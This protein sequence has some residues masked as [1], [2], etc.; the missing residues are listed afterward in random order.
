MKKTS[1]WLIYAFL[2][3][4][5]LITLFTVLHLGKSLDTPSLAQAAETT[6]KSPLAFFAHHLLNPLSL[7]L[8]QI[9]V[10]FPIAQIMG[11]FFNKMGQPRVVGEIVAGIMLGPSILGALSQDIYTFVFP[12]HSLGTLRLMSHI[13]ILIFMFV[14]GMDVNIKAFRKQAHQTLL[15]SHTGIILP[16]I[17]GCLLAGFLFESYKGPNVTFHSF[18]LFMGVAMSITAFPVL[19]RILQEKNLSSSAIGVTALASAAIDDVTAWTLLAL[20]VAWVES[21]SGV[22]VFY[23][24]GFFVLFLM[25]LLLIVRPFLKNHFNNE[26]SVRS[27]KIAF[28]LWLVFVC[29]LVTESIGIHAIFG[30]FIAGVIMPDSQKFKIFISEKLEYFSA[31]FLLPLFFAVVG[32]R[33]RIDLLNDFH[34][35]MVCLVI[36][37]TATF[38]KF[39][40]TS[41]AA[42]FTGMS[43]RDSCSIG[44]LMNARGLM[45]LI[46]L[47]LG[48]EMG[49][50]SEKIFA[51]MIIMALVTTFMTGPLLNLFSTKKL[52]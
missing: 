15:I 17:L 9:I 12:A 4:G 21:G 33:T 42:R 2:I 45:E 22:E 52:A 39:A 1:N 50:F 28:V 48:Y 41:L 25:I 14:I 8:I 5:F 11:Y 44:S 13:G 34:S 49:I 27:H 51:M 3:G 18:A 24:L 7:F 37:F 26:S 40:G 32:I 19:A 35:W 6:S 29:A 38:G 30:A 10:I 16:F 23:M 36:L 46:V 20:I 47:N 31:S 43:W